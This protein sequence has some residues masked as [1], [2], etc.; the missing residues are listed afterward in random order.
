[1]TSTLEQQPRAVL[2]QQK[3]SVQGKKSET[4]PQ[5]MGTPPA[6]EVPPAWVRELFMKPRVTRLIPLD[7]SKRL[8]LIPPNAGLS[9]ALQI[10]HDNKILSAP[11]GEKHGKIHGMVDM[12][13]IVAFIAAKDAEQGNSFGRPEFDIPSAF[14]SSPFT[15]KDL[16]DYSKNDPLVPLSRECPLQ[17]LCKTFA[18]GIHRVPIVGDA[19]TPFGLVSQSAL[20]QWLVQSENWQI[21]QNTPLAT[22]SLLDLGMLKIP[23]K[24]REDRPVLEAVRVL[25]ESK[26][27]SLPI[28][29]EEDELVG[30]FSC[31]DL[32]S[33][34]VNDFN[35]LREPL[36][37][38]LKLSCIWP[39]TAEPTD[40]VATCMARLAAERIHQ[41]WVIGTDGKPVGVVTLTDVM[42]QI[43]RHLPTYLLE[44]IS[45]P[46]VE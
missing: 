40:S 4:Q 9:D 46:T 18:L 34:S 5:H 16:V 21:L 26:H 12:I 35:R 10:L 8:I 13:D 42:R 29:N 41:L 20:N 23:L 38:F 3:G 36:S 6:G 22:S 28:V 19:G 37:K 31:G 39:V 27:N 25:A 43:A 33:L 30:S 11:V 17:T 15:I 24:I 44:D 32:R 7:H 1:M 2:Q 14:T 45:A